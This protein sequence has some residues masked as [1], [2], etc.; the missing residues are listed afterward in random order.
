[1][2]E[3]GTSTTPGT[4][5]DAV[6]AG[7]LILR[8]PARGYRFSVDSLILT[9]FAAGRSSGACADL[10]CGV[11]VVGLGL[12][13]CRAVDRVVGVEIQPRLAELATRNAAIN[14]LE[15][16]FEVIEGDMAARHPLLPAG[17]FRTVV[18]NPPFWRADTGRLPADEERRIACHET[19][20]NL[21][22]TIGAAARLLQREAGRLCVIFPARRLDDLAVSLRRAGMS[23][24]FLIAV[25]PRDQAPAELVLVEARHG[26]GGRMAIGAPLFLKD[27]DGVDTPL[28]ASITEGTF[29]DVLG[30]LPDRRTDRG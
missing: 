12:L 4:S 14:G 25:H 9:W 6:F 21:D 17:G 23:P 26:D 29:I 5:A 22:V 16:A 13:A 20:S 30:S 18:S 10:G 7:R 19:A 15:G 2:N 1:M 3:K 24:T 27:L 28:A 11:G 8:Q